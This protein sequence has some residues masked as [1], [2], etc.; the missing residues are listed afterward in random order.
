MKEPRAFARSRRRTRLA[1][2]ELGEVEGL[3]ADGARRLAQRLALLAL[4]G[5]LREHLMLPPGLAIRENGAV[6]R[7]KAHFLFGGQGQ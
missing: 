5:E 4:E 7:D 1:V 2:L 6:R 3:A